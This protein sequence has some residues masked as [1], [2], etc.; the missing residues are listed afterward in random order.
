[1]KCLTSEGV[2]I[3]EKKKIIN[4][5]SIRG[6]IKGGIAQDGLQK[7]ISKQPETQSVKPPPPPPPKKTS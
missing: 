1:L 4:E 2:E 3:M 6:S 5:G 7:G